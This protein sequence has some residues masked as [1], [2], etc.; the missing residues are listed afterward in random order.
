MTFA[1][2]CAILIA[3]ATTLPVLLLALATSFLSH[4]QRRP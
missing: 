2:Q 1:D 3:T 4:E